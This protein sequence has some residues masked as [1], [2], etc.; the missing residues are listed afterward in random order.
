MIEGNRF[1]CHQ[2]TAYL[3]VTNRLESTIISCI[4]P[5]MGMPSIDST[6]ALFVE[7]LCLY[8]DSFFSR[9]MAL[10]DYIPSILWADPLFQSMII[11]VD[12]L[13]NHPQITRMYVSMKI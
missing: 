6:N 7:F 1:F 13:C 3:L 5:D 9:N 8:R 2:L 4:H 10:D 12:A 11:F